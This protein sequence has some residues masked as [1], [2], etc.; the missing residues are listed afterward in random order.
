MILEEKKDL[1]YFIKNEELSKSQKMAIIRHGHEEHLKK[2]KENDEDI[3]WLIL[4][5]K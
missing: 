1:D 4:S 3:K 5:L 2:L